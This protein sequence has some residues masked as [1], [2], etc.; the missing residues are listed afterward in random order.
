MADDGGR[1]T[2]RQFLQGSQYR[3]DSNLAARQAIYAYQQPRVNLW[4][5]A[6]SLAELDGSETVV[7]VGC[8][9]GR[10]L[11]QL[12][13]E[14][15]N[16]LTVGID[17]SAG[18]LAGV[19]TDDPDQAL[20]QADAT[21][22][23]FQDG[24][25]DVA[26]AMHMLYHVPNPGLAVAELRRIVRPGG[27]VLVLVNSADA[28]R[29]LRQLISDVATELDIPLGSP[30]TWRL[31]VDR[32]AEMV[33]TAFDVVERHEVRAELVVPDPEP[34]VAYVASLAGEQRDSERRDQFYERIRAGVG[35]EIEE[36]GAFCTRT[37][38]GCLVCK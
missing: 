29:E 4:S 24:G 22:L 23:P 35:A 19:A 14:G 34:V 30:T 17:L 38:V 33:S 7:D 25:V 10:Y 12:Q 3:D 18:M 28:L 15:H 11:R 37:A 20:V 1:W 21:R 32:G 16:G 31:D 27:R 2:D 26:L 36:R 5:W 8:G 13:G 9:N 6:L